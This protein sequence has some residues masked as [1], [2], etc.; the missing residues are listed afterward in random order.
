MPPID[1][2]QV[3]PLPGAAPAG[4]GLPTAPSPWPTMPTAADP[5][6]AQS[7]QN[8]NVRTGLDIDQGRR[9][10]TTLG[11]EEER[12]RIAREKAARDKLAAEQN[13]G[14]DT[15]ASQDQAAGH[16]I[17]ISTNL[18][19]LDNITKVD[20]RALAPTWAEKFARGLSKDDPDVVAWSQSPARQISDAALKNTLES[21]IWLSTGAAAPEDQVKRIASTIM[22]SMF[23]SRE[24]LAYRRTLLN[25]YLEQARARAGPANLKVLEVLDNLEKQAPLIYG[26]SSSAPT[27]APPA[28]V[29]LSADKQAQEVPPEYQS[30]YEAAMG[31]IPPGTLSVGKYIQLRQQLDEKYG[32]PRSDFPDADTFVKAYNEGRGSLRI[33]PINRELSMLGKLSAS[34]ASDPGAVGDAYTGA[35]NFA[36]AGGF[37]IP[38]ALA[39]RQ[40]RTAMDLANAAHPDSAAAGDI[41]GGLAPSV[42]LE[43]AL[44][45]RLGG[46]SADVLGNAIYG[47]ARGATGANPED[48][49]LLAGVE[50]AAMGAGGS[51]VGRGVA[52]GAKGFLDPREAA[53]IESLR[54]PD[55]PNIPGVD[56]TTMQRAGMSGIEE[57][58]QGFPGVA[59]AREKAVES[60][61]R[62]NSA[63]V[64]DRIG[65]K[66]P[67]HVRTGQDANA[68]VNTELNAAYNAVRPR[69]VGSLDTSFNNAVAALRTA[70]VAKG[71]V[72]K[73]LWGGVENAV[74]QFRKPDGS[75]DGEGYKAA[76]TQLRRLSEAWG[77]STDAMTQVAAHDMAR[78]AEQVRKQIQAQVGRNTPEVRG[79]LKNLEGAW[80]H[81]ARIDLA[82]RGAAKSTRGVYAPDEYLSAIERSDTSKGKTAISRGKGLDQG[83]AQDAREVLGGK[84]AKRAS[85]RETA[86]GA[87][88]LHFG[89]AAMTALVTA[90]GL[91][92]TPGVK[93]VMQAM[94]DGKLGATPKAVEQAL[95]KTSVGKRILSA[96]GSEARKN[97]LIQILRSEGQSMIEGK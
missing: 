64:L 51:L 54:S 26:S 27:E 7:Q 6:K 17:M 73:E 23:D 4:G 29:K 36:N 25:A 94:V 57:S 70:N 20:P 44:G 69:V 83:Y 87:A 28:D 16:A 56:L 39:D 71:K 49:A 14:T 19:E 97:L 85:V 3:R 81:Q 10:D 33:Q 77:Q 38:E 58:G 9:A 5:F 47:G 35:M 2:S 48:N 22:P 61:N 93:R 42:A 96:T 24:K 68:F 1:P 91:G 59:N 41:L 92:Y 30:E 74:Q 21:A 46:A 53:A 65:K 82:S 55:N 89:G 45:T 84:P 40:N 37:G 12:L 34:A 60:W 86:I 43:K 95:G 62:Q 31:H 32:Y 11:M 52:K 88:S 18:R 8:Q 80:A 90:A 75:Y 63:R 67:D 76:S 72:Y 66:L 78:V 50:G 15:T 79:A 13:G